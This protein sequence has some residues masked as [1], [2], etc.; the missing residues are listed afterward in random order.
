MNTGRNVTHRRGFVLFVFMLVVVFLC[1]PG[2]SE[3][4]AFD[5]TLGWDPNTEPDLSG[6][7]VYYKSVTPGPP[8]LGIE[9]DQGPSPVILTLKVDE[10]QH[11]LVHRDYPG[12]TL[13]GL[14]PKFVYFF[15]VTA[16]DS[17][18]LES[19]FS[20]EVSTDSTAPGK[21][22]NLRSSAPTGTWLKDR[23]V[24]IFWDKAEDGEPGSGVGGYSILWDQNPETVPDTIKD[25]GLGITTKSPILQDGYSYFHIRAVDKAGNWGEAVHFG[26]FLVDTQ[27]PFVEEPPVLDV[28]AN[29]LR[30][31]FSE[32]NM[33]NAAEASNY[34]FDNGMLL[35]G[36]GKDQSRS[37]KIFVFPI[38]PA[39]FRKYTIYAMTVNLNIRDAAGNSIPAD[40][41]VVLINDD[42]GDGMADSWERDHRVSNPKDDPDRDGLINA[43]EYRYGG[44]PYN[45][46]TDGDGMPDSFEVAY[47]L[48]LGSNDADIDSDGDGWTNYQEYSMGTSPSDPSSL[49][50]PRAPEILEVIPHDSAGIDEVLRSPADTSFCARIRA[51]QGIDLTRPGDVILTIYDGQKTYTRDLSYKDV[52]RAIKLTREPDWA[53]SEIWLVYDRVRE[54]TIGLYPF[55]ST[56]TIVVQITDRK[57]LK[58]EEVIFCFK[59]ESK[60]EEA[61][62]AAF[63]Q[64][65]VAANASDL[66]E[67]YDSE[68]RITKGRARGASVYY[69]SAEPVKPRFGPP[70]EMLLLDPALGQSAGEALNLQPPTV[71][72]MPVKVLIPCLGYRDVTG[73]S[74]F[75]FNGLNWVRACDSQGNVLPDG[76]GWMVSGSRVNHNGGAP[77]AVEIKVHHF[78]G[79]V[80]GMDSETGVASPAR[81]ENISSCFISTITGQR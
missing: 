8:Y 37:S 28:A 10:K 66:T 76:E 59:V 36:N 72:N 70:E 65:F 47:R 40:R 52:V 81:S 17:E 64:E 4:F 62:G 73:L 34:S 77:S 25:I 67:P 49:P 2:L 14:N 12:V 54:E 80:A 18:G 30:V 22:A 16:Y 20:N 79:V 21:A 38:N 74:I 75:L 44:N 48:S 24:S 26:P 27:A 31:V 33:Q 43:E 71:F 32:S 19:G 45:P 3:A 53:A 9:A 60:A 58:G 6:Y 15:A 11:L 69:S 55:G 78:S 7:K 29:T 63:E 57:G 39:T 23:I 13:S 5:V 35:S 1:L 46:D 56:I 42:D 51:V 68:I 41:R 50:S 61:K